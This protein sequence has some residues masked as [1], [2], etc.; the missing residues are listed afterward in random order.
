[1]VWILD[2]Q[3]GLISSIVF[4]K[5]LG[6]GADVAIAV[7][8]SPPATSP[9][10]SRNMAAIRRRDTVP[11]KCIRSLLHAQGLRFRVDFPIRIGGARPIRP[12]VVFTRRQ[13]AVFVDGCYFH[14]CPEHGR[15]DGGANAAYWGPKIARN[16]ERDAEQTMLLQSGGWM[17]MRF[18]EHEPAAAVA[19]AVS[20]GLA[21]AA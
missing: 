15:R 17:V 2:T 9:G 20:A 14:G 10:R 8:P 16:R 1:V 5:A 18:W 4:A 6:Y 12:D 11:E 3:D 13:L 19:A 21:A 7:P